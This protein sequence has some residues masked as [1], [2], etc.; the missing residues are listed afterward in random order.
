MDISNILFLDVRDFIVNYIHFYIPEVGK[1]TTANIEK[2]KENRN[3]LEELAEAYPIDL[4]FPQTYEE[5][6]KPIIVRKD[7]QNENN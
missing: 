7:P 5:A 1:L 2:M 6:T 3:D 4:H